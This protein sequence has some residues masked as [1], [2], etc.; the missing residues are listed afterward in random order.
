MSTTIQPRQLAELLKNGTHIDLLDVRTPAEFAE[1]HLTGAKN[2]PLHELDPARIMQQRGNA[3]NE[4]LYLICK[5]GSRGQQA[6]SKLEQAGFSN[7]ANV[8]GGTMACVEAGLPTVHGQKTISLERQVRIAA[9]SLVLLGSVLGAFVHPA[10]IGLAAFVG[11]G[12][13]FA[14][15]TDT[16]GMAMILARMPWN[17]AKSAKNS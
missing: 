3:Q 1:V 8:A 17:Q 9:G 15:I 13:V 16:C 6:C 2:I 7:V 5:S 14:G 11:A 10:W 4:T 12:L